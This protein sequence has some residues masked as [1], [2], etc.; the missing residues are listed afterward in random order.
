M[1]I[2]NQIKKF[3]NLDIRWKL[4]FIGNLISLKLYP[5]S[6]KLSGLKSI[7][8]KIIFF[9]VFQEKTKKIRKENYNL[10]FKINV[11]NQKKNVLVALPR[12]GSNFLRNLIT[13]YVAIENKISDGTPKYDGITDSWKKFSSTIFSADMYS[14]I[15]LD[16]EKFKIRKIFKDNDLIKKQIYFTRH[17][18]Q[19]ADLINIDKVNPVILLRNP[20]DQ[21]KSWIL[22]KSF[23]YNYNKNQFIDE[24][25]SQIRKNLA[26]LN[27]WK[28]YLSKKDSKE[29]L[30]V[31]FTE[32]TKET[33]EI[34]SKILKFYKYEVEYEIIKKSVEINNKEN[35]KKYIGNKN[36]NSIRFMNDKIL[37]SNID[38]FNEIIQSNSE[39]KNII[40]IYNLLLQ[41][42]KN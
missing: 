17:P 13:S 37:N 38:I 15:S 24:L 30:I 11:K 20:K 31:D 22:T 32:L 16:E 39:I 33:Y 36:V 19:E 25:L 28:N 34:F 7:Y 27:Y 26:F 9:I 29:Y 18:I 21:I 23:R 3:I 10:I 6:F 4:R 12:S 41:H 14:S 42:H 8:S 5:S 35:Y 2:L 40:E 1:K